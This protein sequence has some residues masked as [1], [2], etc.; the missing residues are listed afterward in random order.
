[1]AY[2]AA[3]IVFLALAESIGAARSLAARGGYEVNANQELVALGGANLGAGLFGG[4]PVDASLS[5][6][7]TASEA[8]AR[9]Q[10]SSLVTSGFVLLTALFLAPLFQNL[11]NAV[12]AAIVMTSAL[13]LIDVRELRRYLAWRPRDFYLA[14]VALV[15]VIT[16]S[17]LA[18]MAIAVALSLLAILY[19]ASRPYL[20]AL[21][22]LPGDPPAYGDLRRHA[23]ALPAP[24]VLVLRPDVALHFVNASVAK[25]QV[26][27]AIDASD[28]TPRIVV[29]DIGAT[30]DLD[31]AATDALLELLADLDSRDIELRLVHVRASV[32]DRMVRT[33]LAARLGQDR[34][35]LSIEQAILAPVGARPAVAVADTGSDTT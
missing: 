1:M 8:G 29:L 28:P 6:S 34:M 22:R 17:P 14:L 26:I 20:A 25:D 10:V 27:E 19:Q 13:S 18:G 4:F 5:Q 3:G 9:T 33:G 15:A 35:F 11:P 2:G 31:V 24:G 16:T 32:R 21:G 12:L 23:H 7:A 30:S